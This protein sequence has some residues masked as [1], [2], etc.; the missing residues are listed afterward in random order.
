MELFTMAFWSS[1]IVIVGIDLFLAGDN[2]VVIALAARKLPNHQRG[3]AIVLGAAGAVILRAIA[4]I[5]VVYLLM[6][7]GLHF[8]GGLLLVWIAYRLLVPE[9]KSS[10]EVKAQTSL[11]GAVRTIVIADALMGL[12]NV[13]AVAGAAQNDP[14][15]VIVGLL[16]SIPLLMGGSAVI[17]NLMDRFSW[18]IYVGAGILAMT[19]AR[20][21]FAEPLV[22]DWLGNWSVWLEW[23]V[24]A[25]VIA[26]VL[27]LGWMSQ[28]RISRQHDQ[29]QA[30]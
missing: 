3:K 30:V 13:L 19:A 29:N 11:W 12:D 28:K 10:K 21:L 24:V 27:G 17:L 25:F 8:I 1:L 23:P 9:E 22:K 15:L 7:P 18:L 2:A 16:I 20:M 5:L 4:T 6:I 26:A 14:L